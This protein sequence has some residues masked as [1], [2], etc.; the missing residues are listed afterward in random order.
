MS[1]FEKTPNSTQSSKR[2]TSGLRAAFLGVSLIV[3][4]ACA[5]TTPYQE[6]SK[7]GAFDG[8]T[9]TMIENDRARVSFAGNSL[10]ERETV[11]NYLL[12]RSAELAVERGFDNFKLIESDT[13]KETRLQSTGA[14]L[15]YGHNSFR[16]SYF[17]PRFGW[18]RFGRF[19]AFNS[20]GG[21]GFGRRGFGSRGFG[22][23]GFGHSGFG[24]SGFGFGHSG[25]DVREITKYRAVAEVKFGRGSGANDDKTY[26]AREVLQNLG[27]TIVYPE[28]AEDAVITP[29]DVN[30]K[31]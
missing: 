13:E 8:Y 4:S 14:G 23:R 12:Y 30:N 11:E 18:S 24:H 3:L 22:G 15:G 31:I 16:Y 20:F 28:V 21:R 7:P 29:E 26:N 2:L 19:S 5:T 25:F 1:F 6:A 9:Q 27:P 17:S 10:T